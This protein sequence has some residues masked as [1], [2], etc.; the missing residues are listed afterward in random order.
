MKY[1]YRI[2]MDGNG[3]FVI[4]RKATRFEWIRFWYE[5]GCEWPDQP[6]SYEWMHFDY[7]TYRR[8]FDT[9]KEAVEVLEKKK[10]QQRIIEASEERHV[11]MEA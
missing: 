1:K 4:E 5:L 2:L 3:K 11:V 10:E 7:N 6:N 8:R 9:I